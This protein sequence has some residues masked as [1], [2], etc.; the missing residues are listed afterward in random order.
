MALVIK[1]RVRESTTTT[2]T[3]TIALNGAVAGFR[4]FSSAMANGDTTW[5]AIILPAGDWETGV[6]TWVTGN[7]LQRTTVIDSSNCGAAVN[8][9]SGT[10]DVLMALPGPKA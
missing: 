10:K 4:A 6:G 5:Y 3:G 7:Q 8:F 2:G 1:D 9:G